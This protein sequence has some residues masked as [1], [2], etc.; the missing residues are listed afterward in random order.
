MKKNIRNVA[1]AVLISP[2]DYYSF[3][4]ISNIIFSVFILVLGTIFNV[5]I[6]FINFYF[7]LIHFCLLY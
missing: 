2:R 4:N 3:I 5:Y 6:V 7:S 1:L